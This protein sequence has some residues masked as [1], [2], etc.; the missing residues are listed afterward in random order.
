M[1]T[2]HLQHRHLLVDW[3]SWALQGLR[4][5]AGRALGSMLAA[6]LRYQSRRHLAELD[7]R[8]LKD[9][10]LTRLDVVRETDKPFWN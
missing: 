7:D 3:L 6:Y 2:I 4:M 5:G 8:A 9:I 10:G 1:G